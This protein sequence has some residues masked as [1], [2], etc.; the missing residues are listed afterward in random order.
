MKKQIFS[1]LGILAVMVLWAALAVTAWCKPS[2][3]I[4]LSERRKLAQFPELTG[5]TI[6]SG[7]FMTNFET[8]TLDQFPLRDGFRQIK[9]L[10]HYYVLQQGDN[11]GIFLV[12]GSASKLE[13][14]LNPTSVEH[15]S[16]HFESIYQQYLKDSGSRIWFAMV[17]DKSYFLAQPNG[18]P[19]M[20]YDALYESM[21]A[22]LP[23]AQ[24]VDITGGLSA[25]HYYRTDSHWRQETLIP[26]ART[27]CASLGTALPEEQDYTPREL[28]REFY[29]V[30][31]GQAALP[32]QPDTLTVLESPLLSQCTVYN[33]ETQKETAVYDL[34]KL[35]SRDLYD[36]FLSGAAPLLTIENPG[37][38][39]DRELIVF[40]DSFG[41]SIVPLLLEGYSKITVVDTRYLA[42]DYIG[43]FVE[44]TGQ[45]VLMLYSTTMLNSSLSLK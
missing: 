31:Y 2:D 25:E 5:K 24:F 19:A 39:A 32:M 4:S 33:W 44:F 35:S 10:V 22:A 30:Y 11:N 21:E 27:L 43:Q 6:L 14:P 29:G 38:Q 37:A 13:Y 9:S 1:R 15:A 8:Y 36:V 12:E 3:E 23:W 7:E 20:D 16:A 28:T 18:Y 41:S 34:D 17:P 45:D 42:K 26:T 40:R